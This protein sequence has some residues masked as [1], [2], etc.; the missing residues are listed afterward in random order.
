MENNISFE[1]KIGKDNKNG[2]GKIIALTAVIVI[3]IACI[4]G[5]YIYRRSNI[6]EIAIGLSDIDLTDDIKSEM[7]DIALKAEAYYEKNK[8]EKIL[9][10]QYGMLYSYKDKMNVMA[11][12]VEEGSGASKDELAEMDIL[13]MLPKDALS[14][15]DSEEGLAIFVSINSSSGYYVASSNG[16]G[17]IYTEEEFS[18]LLMKY[19]PTHGD[20]RNPVRGSDEH[21][22]IIKAAGLEGDDFDIKHIACDDKYAVVVANSITDPQNIKEEALVNDDGWKV[23]NEDLAEAENSYIEINSVYPDMDLGLLPIYNIS[24]YEH[25]TTSGM[26]KIVD[27]LVSQGVMTEDEK[28]DVYACGC[29][30]FAYVQTT[31]GKRF[32]GYLNDEKQLQ[33]NEFTSIEEV[34]A[35]MVECQENP[36]VFI[37]RFE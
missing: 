35:Y 28:E 17:A 20:V 7:Q 6:S 2:K 4:V 27:S 18:N 36:P 26:S 13:Y 23:V 1:S 19:A 8:T 3:I 21:T 32:V 34:L 10:S 24:D 31:S 22:E 25:I 16:D 33:F 14:I 12:D 15:T 9:T 5:Y 30:R 37:A 11:S 29:E